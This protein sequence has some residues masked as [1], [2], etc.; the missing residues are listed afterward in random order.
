M[1][2][3]E[4]P[5]VTALGYQKGFLV[6]GGYAVGSV[7]FQQGKCQHGFVTGTINMSGIP[8]NADIVAAYLYWQTIATNKAQ[9]KLPTFR[10]QKIAAA[11]ETV[12]P[13]DPSIRAVLFRRI[14]EQHVHDV[15]LP[16]G[17][18]ASAAVEARYQR[19]P[20]AGQQLRLA[21]QRSRP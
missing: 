15:W 21:E 10:G 11:K 16:R 12:K 18:A 9:V 7:D 1:A 8:A 5:P 4:P 14:V 19:H 17:R 6:T 20:R 3:A 13:L 2:R